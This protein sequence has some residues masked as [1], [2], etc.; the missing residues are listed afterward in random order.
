MTAD[1][2]H[3]LLEIVA[4]VAACAIVAVVLAA[5]FMYRPV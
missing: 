3:S 5:V 1:R 4:V 2:I